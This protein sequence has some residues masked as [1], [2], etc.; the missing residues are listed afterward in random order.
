MF[1]DYQVDQDGFQVAHKSVL[2]QWQDGKRVV[3][4]PDEL[5]NGKAR[6]PTPTWNQR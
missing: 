4:W 2:L 5:A 3:V 6:F 1:G